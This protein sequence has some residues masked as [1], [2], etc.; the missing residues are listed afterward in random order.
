MQY[1][2]SL[3]SLSFQPLKKTEV[4][5]FMKDVKYYTHMKYI[6][7]RYDMSSLV[8]QFPTL[9]LNVILSIDI[10]VDACPFEKRLCLS[11]QSHLALGF[12]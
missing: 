8:R 4:I 3:S 9:I 1:F 2:Y 12:K 11:L 5:E 6:K 7:Q 10:F